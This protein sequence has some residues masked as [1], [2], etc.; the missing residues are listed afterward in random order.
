MPT[1]FSHPLTLLLP[2]TLSTPTLHAN[3]V[4]QYV[5]WEGWALQDPTYLPLCT[6]L[7]SGGQAGLRSIC[8]LTSVSSHHLLQTWGLLNTCLAGKITF[9]CT[10]MAVRAARKMLEILKGNRCPGTTQQ[11]WEKR[12]AAGLQRHF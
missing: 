8:V 11:L 3:P 1:C 10:P 6:G 12:G 5:S 9:L 4:S 7:K 2:R